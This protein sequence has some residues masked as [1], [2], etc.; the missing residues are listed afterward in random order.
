MAG[1]GE[2][3]VLYLSP[4][5]TQDSNYRNFSDI[6]ANVLNIGSTLRFHPGTYEMGSAN[7]DGI[8]FEGIGSRN[9]VVLANL[10]LTTAN[11]T[12]FKNVTLSGNSGIT[13]SSSRSIFIA[14]GSTGTV[15]F[16]SVRFV[17]ADFG[18]DNQ[19]LAALWMEYCDASQVDRA[20]RNNSVVAANVAWSRLNASSNAFYT[21][22]NT[23]L[24]VVQVVMSTSGGSNT[25]NT[26][27]TITANIP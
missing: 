8:T 10:L 1:V 17:N 6:D 5:L 24:K 22:G 11:T 2:K 19:S 16:E 25:G 13:A 12:T 20:I 21:G 18:I 7:V 9:D 15:R 4:T 23:G 27:R 14:G 3:Q 26:T